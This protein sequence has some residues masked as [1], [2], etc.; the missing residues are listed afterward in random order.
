[1]II[2]G[3][4]QAFPETIEVF[5]E[6]GIHCFGCG[7]SAHETIEQGVQVHGIDPDELVDDLNFIID[8][9]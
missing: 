6:Y 1:M 9:S 8:N 4:V 3:V 7:M 2:A 5:M